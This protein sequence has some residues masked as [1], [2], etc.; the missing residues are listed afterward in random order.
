MSQQQPY[1]WKKSSYSGGE[2]N[3]CVEIGT[4]GPDIGIRDTKDR[5]CGTLAVSREA[6]DAFQRRIT[7]S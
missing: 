7:G 5:A 4:G 3:A 6:F 2:N 1:V